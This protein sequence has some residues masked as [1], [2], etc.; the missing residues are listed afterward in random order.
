MQEGTGRSPR[1]LRRRC[2]LRPQKPPCRAVWA[3]PACPPAGTCPHQYPPFRPTRRKRPP[4]RCL[5]FPGPQGVPA[6][7]EPGPT[8]GRPLRLPAAGD[9][10]G[11]PPAPTFP[12]NC[13]LHQLSPRKKPPRCPA[14]PGSGAACL[15]RTLISWGRSYSPTAPARRKAPP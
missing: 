2:G 7:P 3:A 4:R 11:P 1:R 15:G 5:P 10:A 9:P 8:C 14:P 12:R 6:P 13:P